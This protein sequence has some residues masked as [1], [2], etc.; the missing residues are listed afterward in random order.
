MI[1]AVRGTDW[2][3]SY[4]VG[5]TEIFVAKGRVLATDAVNAVSN[6]VLL[7]PGEGVHFIAGAPHSPVVRWSQ[8]KINLYVAATRV[9]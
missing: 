2:I 8:E 1:A 5:K 6:W 3:E 4:T 7:S 9:P